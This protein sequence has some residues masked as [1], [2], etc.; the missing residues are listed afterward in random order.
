MNWLL[1]TERFPA[2]SGAQCL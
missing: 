2:P 1:M